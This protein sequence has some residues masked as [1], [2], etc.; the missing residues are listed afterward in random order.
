MVI[1]EKSDTK[2]QRME[3][4]SAGMTQ[5]WDDKNDFYLLPNIP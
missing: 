1:E 5:G 2:K 4:W 3:Q